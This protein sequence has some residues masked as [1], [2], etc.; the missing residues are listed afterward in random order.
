MSVD[1]SYT[2]NKSDIVNLLPCQRTKLADSQCD[3]LMDGW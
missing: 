1:A 2:I 3:A